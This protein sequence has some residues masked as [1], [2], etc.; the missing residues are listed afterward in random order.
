[1]KHAVKQLEE[2]D[3]RNVPQLTDAVAV[4]P[5]EKTKR[6][7]RIRSQSGKAAAANDWRVG[8]EV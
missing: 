3:E 4:C 5:Q 8:C 6:A 7:T 2:V 1:M